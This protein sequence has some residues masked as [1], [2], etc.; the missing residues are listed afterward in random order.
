MK[1]ST[2]VAREGEADEPV[3]ARQG[4]FRRAVLQARRVKTNLQEWEDLMAL[5]RCVILPEEIT[6][7]TGTRWA[8]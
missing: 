6:M 7:K 8:T 1:R 3:E 4:S 5:S 2:E